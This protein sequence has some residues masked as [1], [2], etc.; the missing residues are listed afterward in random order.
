MLPNRLYRDGTKF[1]TFLA[2]DL[3]EA[4]KLQFFG[5]SM[6]RWELEERLVKYND[7]V[8]IKSNATHRALWDTSRAD[9]FICGITHMMTIPQYSI[10]EYNFTKDKKLEYVN[11]YGEVTGSE[12]VNQDEFEYKAL[13]RGW[14][15]TLAMV[16]KQGYRVDRKG[17]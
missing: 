7:T 14:E 16:E 3:D 11:M 1:K 2:K 5:N 17:L 15:V 9:G 4:Y 13:A 6:T 8:C 10:L 12:I